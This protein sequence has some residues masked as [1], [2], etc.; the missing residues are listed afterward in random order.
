MAKRK[1]KAKAQRTKRA[2]GKSA[3]RKRT[4]KVSPTKRKRA[5]RTFGRV[6]R[7][8]MKGAQ[9]VRPTT[10]TNVPAV[11]TVIVD[12]IEEPLPG[13]ITVTEFEETDIRDVDLDRERKD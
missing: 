10:L 3:A 6:K 8:R 7:E 9:K 2:T 12:V 11:E 4:R 13:V 5:K 1:K